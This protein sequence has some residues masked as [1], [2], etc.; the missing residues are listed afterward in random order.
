MTSL[1]RYLSIN[2]TMFIL[3]ITVDL[4]TLNSLT[5]A[6]N[7]SFSLNLLKALSCYKSFSCPFND[8]SGFFAY[9]NFIDLFNIFAVKQWA[10]Q[11][12]FNFIFALSFI[13]GSISRIACDIKMEKALQYKSDAIIKILKHLLQAKILYLV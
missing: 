6:T 10:E 8:D 11:L 2:V 1:V 12:L 3:N 5:I 4:F 7:F 13:L 9:I